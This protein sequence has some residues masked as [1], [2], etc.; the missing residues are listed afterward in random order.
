MLMVSVWLSGKSSLLSALG[1]HE[2]PVPDHIDIYHLQREMAPSEKTALQ[3]VMEVDAERVRLE[4]EAEQL[5]TMSSDG[6]SLSHVS[7]HIALVPRWPQTW[8]TWNTQGFLWTWKIHE[9]LRE[10]CATSRKNINKQ[11]IFSSSLKY[12][13]ETAVD[14]VNSIVRNRDKVRV[15]WRPVILLELMRNDPWLRSLLHLLFVAV[16]YG[17]LGEFFSRTL[18]PPW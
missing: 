13:C 3:S 15:W 2:L 18:W 5:T 1:N 7:L 11:S 8:K 14:W 12:L 16:T 6:I 10:F 4:H 9:I 17:K